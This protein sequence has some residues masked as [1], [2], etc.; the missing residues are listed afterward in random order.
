[1]QHNAKPPAPRPRPTPHLVYAAFLLAEAYT[2]TGLPQHLA[3]VLV[4]AVAVFS[5][6]ANGNALFRHT[7]YAWVDGGKRGQ[8][9]VQ[10]LHLVRFALLQES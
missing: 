3:N 6:A 5:A 10:H 7:L 1:L 9:E 8:R 2:E 4:L